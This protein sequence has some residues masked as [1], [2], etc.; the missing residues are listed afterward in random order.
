MHTFIQ[1]IRVY[2]ASVYAM[3]RASSTKRR[4]N[5]AVAKGSRDVGQILCK[6]YTDFQSSLLHKASRSW[7]GIHGLCKALASDPA[8]RSSNSANRQEA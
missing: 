7:T 1:C 2:S 6:S 8:G 5:V 3:L 4:D